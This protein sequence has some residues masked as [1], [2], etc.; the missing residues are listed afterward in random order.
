VDYIHFPVTTFT[1]GALVRYQPLNAGKTGTLQNFV[2]NVTGNNS[3]TP[4]TITL[5]LDSVNTPLQV[6]VPP[7]SPGPSGTIYSDMVDTFPVAFGHL[8]YVSVS[9]QSASSSTTFVF[10]VEDA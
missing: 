7:G 4:V 9:G 6:I 1:Q 3:T 10:S 5:T 8:L 2:V